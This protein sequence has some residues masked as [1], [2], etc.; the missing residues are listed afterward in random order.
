M[1]AA[2]EQLHIPRVK[3][4]RPVHSYKGTLTLGD[5]KTYDTAITINVERY[6]CTAIAKPPTASSFVVKT[7]LVDHDESTLQ[8]SATLV[9]SQQGDE[10][11]SSVRNQRT[12]QV[13]DPRSEERRVGKECPV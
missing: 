8:S 3:V 7:G 4:V 11:F 10:D 12:Y 5:N 1:A 13:D 9:A 2:V 6:P